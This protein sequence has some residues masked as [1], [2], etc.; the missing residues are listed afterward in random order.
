MQERDLII[1]FAVG[2]LKSAVVTEAPMSDGYVLQLMK[3]GEKSP[4][5]CEKRPRIAAQKKEDCTRVFKTIDA[6]VSMAKNIGFR[7]IEVEFS[8]LTR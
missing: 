5:F 3:K 2:G 8:G 1:L 6:A 7:K 4:I